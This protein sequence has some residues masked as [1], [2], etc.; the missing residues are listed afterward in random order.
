MSTLP[1][2]REEE[3]EEIDKLEEEEEE[4]EEVKEEKEDLKERHPNNKLQPNKLLNHNK[5]EDV[6]LWKYYLTTFFFIC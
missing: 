1:K 4:E 3:S 6:L 2:I 5:P